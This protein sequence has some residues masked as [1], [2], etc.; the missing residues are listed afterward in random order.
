[1]KKKFSSHIVLL[2]GGRVFCLL[3]VFGI[4]FFGYPA[5]LFLRDAKFLFFF[6]FLM[7]V[8]FFVVVFLKIIWSFF[9]PLAWGKLI[10][11]NEGVRWRCLF[12][13]SVF[14]SWNECKYMG[15][16][17]FSNGNVVKV[18][19]YGNGFKYIYFSSTPYPKEFNGKINKLHCKEG[20]IKFFPANKKICSAVL[21]HVVVPAFV[22]YVEDHQKTKKRSGC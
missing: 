15:F 7:I 12:K 5:V 6:F 14:L 8:S 10:V 22:T 2:L 9:W 1:M 17:T 11:D 20:F 3:M 18:D 4:A 21:E 13:K 16:E 19:P